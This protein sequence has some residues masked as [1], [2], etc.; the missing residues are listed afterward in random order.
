MA[1]SRIHQRRTE[2]RV[3][4]IAM[5]AAATILLLPQLGSAHTARYYTMTW[6]TDRT[7]LWR[8]VNTYPTTTTYRSRIIDAMNQ[9][10]NINGALQWHNEAPDYGNFSVSTCPQPYY[11]KNGIH[12]R[13]ISSLGRAVV[14]GY[15]G[16]PGEIWS[17][18]M[19]IDSSG[20]NWYT[21]AAGTPGPTQIDLLSVASH[22]WGHMSGS[23]SAGDGFGHFPE[24]DAVCPA[25]ANRHTM[26]PTIYSGTVWMRT[27]APHDVEEFNEVY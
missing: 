5:I 14:C 10:N 24:N 3:T 9:W 6:Q 8:F 17:A 25:D 2:F 26:C 13:D 23:V 18:Q 11:Q 16:R 1:T 12:W 15:P 27:L 19:I 4:C 20:P 7:P 21:G 22:E